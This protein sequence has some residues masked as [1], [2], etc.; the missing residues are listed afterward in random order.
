MY[1]SY[2]IYIGDYAS[3]YLRH[4]L[5]LVNIPLF[6]KVLYVLHAFFLSSSPIGGVNNSKSIHKLSVT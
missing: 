6:Y 5:E 1:E 4:G 3:L 2:K